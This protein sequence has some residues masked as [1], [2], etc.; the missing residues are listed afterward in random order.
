MITVM[1]AGAVFGGMRSTCSTFAAPRWSICSKMTMEMLRIM[2]W[3]LLLTSSVRGESCGKRVMYLNARS[4]MELLTTPNYPNDY[5][6]NEHC[7]WIISAAIPTQVVQI[8]SVASDLVNWDGGDCEDYVAVYDGIDSTKPLLKKW[9]GGQ[10]VVIT[11]SGKSVLVVFHTDQHLTG[12]GF[13]L[14]YYSMQKYSSKCDPDNVVP[15]ETSFN[16]LFVDL[17]SFTAEEDEWKEQVECSYL[18]TSSREDAGQT[19]TLEL[20]RPIKCSDGNFTVYDGPDKSSPV[21]VSWCY[22]TDPFEVITTTRPEALVVFTL[23]RPD[24][25]WQVLRVRAAARSRKSGCSDSS[26][27]TLQ[28][29]SRP[30]FLS[31]PYTTSV[32]GDQPCSVRLWSAKRDQTLRV[33]IVN[34]GK[35]GLP[36]GDEGIYFYDGYSRFDGARLLGEGCRRRTAHTSTHHLLV[37]PGNA[38]PVDRPV[39]LRVVAHYSPCNNNTDSR[40]ADSDHIETLPSLATDTYGYPNDALC[41]FLLTSAQERDAVEVEVQG[42][43][44]GRGADVCEGDYIIFYDG[45]N[46]STPVLARWCGALNRRTTVTSSGHQLLAVV[47]S[48]Q[49]D[50]RYDGFTLEYYAVPASGRCAHRTQLTVNSTKQELASPNYPFYYPINSY[51]E[52]LLTAEEGEEVVVKVLK[53]E[54]EGDCSDMVRVYDGKEKSLEKSL[55][56]W[57]GGETP[58]FV[59]TGRHLLLIFSANDRWNS[60]GFKLEFYTLGSVS[61]ARV[62]VWAIIGGLLAAII[63]IIIIVISLVLYLRHWR[64]EQHKI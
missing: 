31:F 3:I 1:A 24:L 50:N 23:L 12:Q 2:T 60:G 42:R 7:Q 51:C 17:P 38:F 45:A 37:T 36:C 10:R 47:V 29:S 8:E 32:Q 19:L 61:G 64:R 39:I 63:V 49:H 62:S 33:D 4:S 28:L 16:P 14:K 20:Y 41:R 34:G 11:S 15:L 6:N 22:G 5:D 30:T 43:M 9:C 56:R 25:N 27:P 18:F 26:I 54:M 59:S 46:T 57:C 35:D 55:G 13:A 40:I 21:I 52:W 58:E 48:D 44:V 53:T